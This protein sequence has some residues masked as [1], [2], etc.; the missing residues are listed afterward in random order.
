MRR[1]ISYYISLLQVDF[2]LSLVISPAYDLC[3]LLYGSS[4]AD[5]TPADWD[6]LIHHYHSELCDRLKQLNYSKTIPSAKEIQ[7]NIPVVGFHSTLLCLFIIGLRNMDAKDGDDI[8]AKFVN[9]DETNKYQA[10]RIEFFSN[11]K[12]TNELKR[13]LKFFESKGQL[14]LYAE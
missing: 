1:I 8:V 7:D 13:L 2:S 6:K 10:D 12:C 14:D 9:K 5:V 11:Q 3:M 4:N